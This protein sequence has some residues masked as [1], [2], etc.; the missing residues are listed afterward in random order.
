MLPTEEL[1]EQ[2]NRYKLAYKSL[3]VDRDKALI[4]MTK[5]TELYYAA[6]KVAIDL[7]R[8]IRSD[9]AR[10]MPDM[11]QAIQLVEAM[12]DEVMKSKN[13]MEETS[14]AKNETAGV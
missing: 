10:P 13:L 3:L 6:R 11:P 8:D 2:V 7:Y 1:I 5:W 14:N 4:A 12:I 9:E